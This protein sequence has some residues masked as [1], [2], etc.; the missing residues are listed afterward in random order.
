MDRARLMKSATFPGHEI[1]CKRD[2]QPNSR[3]YIKEVMRP[4]YR[5]M[6]SMLGFRRLITDF[7]NT[8]ISRCFGPCVGLTD[9]YNI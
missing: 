7:G 8:P 1:S 2:G 4:I 9:A 3:F 6:P 5:M